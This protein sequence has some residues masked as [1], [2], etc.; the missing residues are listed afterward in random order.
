MR[1][2]VTGRAGQVGWELQRTLAPLGE[3]TAVGREEVDLQQ[4]KAIADI[5]RALHP[6]VIVNAAAYTAVD[7]AE[8]DFETAMRVNAEAPDVLAREAVQLGALLVHLS[9]DYVFDGSKPGPYVEEDLPHPINRYGESKLAGERAVQKAGG[10][11]VILRTGWVYGARGNNFLRTILRLAAQRDELRV[12]CDQIGAPTWSRMLAEVIAQIVAR[13]QRD[14][15]CAGVPGLYHVTAAGETSW[16]GFAVEG[17]ELARRLCGLSVRARQV[18]AISSAEYP[19]PARRPL[20]SRLSNARIT[21]ALGARMISWDAAL[22]MC[23]E[24]A[25]ESRM[26]FTE[27]A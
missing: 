23:V 9:T 1:L 24:D 10:S 2:L 4:P 16:H 11:Y 21:A 8:S 27:P 22:R 14:R 12:V 18:V 13:A 20:N 3:V 26:L 5:V 19:F 25:A 7:R 6:Q 17:I 15:S